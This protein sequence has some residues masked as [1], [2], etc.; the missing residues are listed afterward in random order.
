[1]TTA[2]LLESYRDTKTGQSLETLAIW[3]HMI[4][5]EEVEAVFSDSL[6]SLYD[7]ALEQ[8]LEQL[9]AYDRTRGLNSEERRELQSLL[10]ALAKK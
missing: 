9:I 3:N 2:Q 8:R 10:T 4:V 7:S 6:A 1:M 5:D